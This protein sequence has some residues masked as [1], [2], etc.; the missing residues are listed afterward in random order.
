[1]KQRES[2]G[3]DSGRE[4]ASRQFL[5]FLLEDEEY[6][7]DVL[8]VREIRVWESATPLPN[9]APFIKGVINLRGTLVPVIDLRERFGLAPRPYGPRTVVIVLAVEEGGR[10]R[11]MGL[12]VDGVSNVCSLAPAEISPAPDFC[13]AVHADFITG[14]ATQAEGMLIL[15]DSD[16]LLNLEEIQATNLF[17][18]IR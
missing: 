15:L 12:V 8:K 3:A 7:V 9:T 1:M 5:S 10:E 16:R 4:G 11:I 2:N 17:G 18:A 14:L 13:G 6:A